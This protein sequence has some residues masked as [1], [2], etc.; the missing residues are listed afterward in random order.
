MLDT[1]V[2]PL[3]NGGI[4]GSICSMISKARL[5]HPPVPL[6]ASLLVIVLLVTVTHRYSVKEF[7][8]LSS[9]S[10]TWVY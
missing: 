5:C 6:L 9:D 3:G 4:G 1:A 8:L 10:S 7:I 2:F